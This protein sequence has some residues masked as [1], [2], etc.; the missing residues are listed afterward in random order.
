MPA[1]RWNILLVWLRLTPLSENLL[2]HIRPEPEGLVT[3][4]ADHSPHGT[5]YGAAGCGLIGAPAIDRKLLPTSPQG[6]ADASGQPDLAQER[7][8]G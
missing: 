2:P 8:C 7:L 3:Y 1:G 6:A 4:A 5:H